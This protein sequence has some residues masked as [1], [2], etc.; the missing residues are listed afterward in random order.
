MVHRSKKMTFA[1]IKE[2][3]GKKL[4]SWKRSLLSVGGR[5]VLVKAVGEAISIYLLAC[6]KLPETLMEDLHKMMIHFWWASVAWKE[7]WLGLV[8][9]KCAGKRARVGFDARTEGL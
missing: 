9:I 7:S 1:Y 8:E 6:F 2:K 4:H 5:E 3:V